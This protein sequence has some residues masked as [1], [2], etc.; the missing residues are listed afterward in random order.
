MCCIRA[1]LISALLSTG[2]T[3]WVDAADQEIDLSGTWSMQLDPNDAGVAQQ[4]WMKPL[5]STIRLPGSLA[6]RGFGDRPSMATQWTGTIRPEIWQLPRY[7]PYRAA[8]NFKMPFWL[9]P[10][11]VYRGPAWYQK[12]VEIPPDWDDDHVTL[13]LERCHWFTDVWLDDD[14]IG[15][16]ES[17]SVPHEFALE[18]AAKTGRHRLTVR[19][20]NRLHINVGQNSHSVTDHTQTNW[21]GIVGR[22]EL[23]RRPAIHLDDLQIYPDLKQQ[24]VR[25]RVQVIGDTQR[26]A[27]AELSLKAVADGRT[28]GSVA[29]AVR[30]AEGAAT[31]NIDVPLGDQVRVWD[32]HDPHLYTLQATLTGAGV[33]TDMR[34]VSFGMREVHTQGT[35]FV[36]NG[37]PI[38][39]R[40]T[41]ECCIF[42]RTGYPPTDIAAWKRII[43]TCKAFGLNHIRFHSWCPPEAA[44]VA[45][46]QLGFY[47]Q[48]ECASWA[49]GDASVGDGKPLDKWLY[50]EADRILK[51]YGNHPSFLLLAYGN[52][53]RGPGNRGSA[54]LGPWVDHYKARA[55]RQLV[56]C[57]AGWPYIPENQFHV[58][59]H[60]LRQH[61]EFNR[62][63]PETTK[64]YGQIVQKYEVPCI[65]H[66]TGQWC[67]FLNLDEVKKYTG[68]LKPRNF[69]IVGDFLRAHGLLD[70]ARDFLLASGRFQTLLY[71][72]EIE[73][74]RRTSGFGGFQ[75]LDLH[76]F[77]GQGTALV[78]VLDPFWDPKPYVTAED[79]RRFCGPVTPLAR[80]ATR[81][82]TSDQTLKADIDVAQF[83]P[84]DLPAQRVVWSLQDS[85]GNTVAQGQLPRA[86]LSTGR[87]QHVGKLACSLN[88]V[89]HPSQLVLKVSLP[90]TPY[91]NDW[92]IWVY[93]PDFSTAAPADVMVAKSL[94]DAVVA[95]LEAGGK[96][97]LAARP[98]AIACDTHGSFE[99]IFWNRLWFP[100]QPIHTLGIL[101]DPSHPAL[102]SFPTDSHSN[103]QWWD[104]CNHSKPIVLD[105]LPGQLRPIVQVIDDWNTCRKLG[106]VI[107]A[108]VGKGRLILC[109]IDIDSHLDER[110]VA[111]Q[112]RH[113]LIRYMTSDQ[114]KPT[115][116]VSL[117]SIRR[118]FRPLSRLQELDAN[119]KADSE[120][121]GYPAQNA[122]D[123]NPATI[124]HTAWGDH[125]AKHPH[126]LVVD[127][128]QPVELTGLKYLPRQD[129]TNGRI[130][131]F[132]VYVSPD[133]V[134]WGSPVAAER[135]PEGKTQQVVRFSPPVR[136]RYVKLEA[137]SETRGQDFTAV[138][139][140]DIMTATSP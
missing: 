78:G 130:A 67:V 132:A 39:L 60:P 50:R 93:P 64:D 42:P 111:R 79:F 125:A 81:V 116:R 121:P 21:N 5:A 88:A 139:E 53:P 66:E 87:L 49:N 34:V 101:C 47:F 77:P 12:E 135:W 100:T 68:V 76:D 90:G 35:Q 46:D 13:F 140:M 15:V 40:G 62:S 108:R 57:A 106:Y 92:S 136:G 134:N 71:K 6:E 127:L 58:M 96:V 120:Q 110:P 61:G 123:G 29:T 38:F 18:P 17:L 14:K 32:E 37:R 11:R 24:L 51:E 86:N 126:W 124:W 4:W 28:V 22:I 118:L 63:Q 48:V 41:L 102:A 109:S 30:L 36:L 103:W 128:Q 59:H 129:M 26:E 25:V 95:R 99:P 31:V 9:Q 20:D 69:E 44:F 19:V 7:A 133:G 85:V 73:V 16:G 138:A 82:W 119:V 94:D 104:L 115:I 23:R 112:L 33:H 1:I 70:Q 54:Y 84:T 83:G 8:S 55:T 56:T 3:A 137:R 72:E 52:E 80:L 105:A 2:M 45:A 27:Q 98:Q 107:E 113:S 131:Q 91:R 74:M 75:L 65:S 114:F 43:S 97:L 122:V 89:R 10:D 117:E